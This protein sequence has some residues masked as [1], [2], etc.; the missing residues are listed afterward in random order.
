MVGL[1]RDPEE[2]V[3]KRLHAGEAGAPAFKRIAQRPRD[4]DRHDAARPRMTA[5]IPACRAVDRRPPARAA[6][7]SAQLLRRLRVRNF[8]GELIDEPATIA[9]RRDATRAS[10]PPS[11]RAGSAGDDVSAALARGHGAAR[12]SR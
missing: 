9:A 5:T 1:C 4:A 11:S 7:T 12:A 10:T 6:S 8:S 3:E 2:Y